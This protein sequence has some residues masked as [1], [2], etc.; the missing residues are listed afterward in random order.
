[1][2]MRMRPGSLAH[3][4]PRAYAPGAQAALPEAPGVSATLCADSRDLTR[5]VALWTDDSTGRSP[6]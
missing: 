6:R 5:L 2:Q 1:M 3:A 4:P